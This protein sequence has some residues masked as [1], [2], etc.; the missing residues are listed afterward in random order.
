[1]SVAV[2][3]TTSSGCACS[4][5]GGSGSRAMPARMPRPAY[6]CRG[7][8]GRGVQGRGL[9]GESEACG[10]G[11]ERRSRRGRSRGPP[12]KGGPAR[13]R[14]GTCTAWTLA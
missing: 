6:D 11:S 13:D 2:H 9:R 5:A 3:A 12:S 4:A 10:G 14:L 1:M 7:A 8:R